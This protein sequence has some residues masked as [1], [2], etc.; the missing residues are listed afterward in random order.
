MSDLNKCFRCGMFDIDGVAVCRL[1][2]HKIEQPMSETCE[3][4]IQLD[5]AIDSLNVDIVNLHKENN[6][7]LETNKVISGAN[8]E[9]KEEGEALRKTIVD[10]CNLMRPDLHEHKYDCTL[11]PSYRKCSCVTGEREHFIQE[12]ENIG[13]KG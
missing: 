1:H 3:Y 12:N 7:H 10:A 5:D 8:H 2:G 11:T 13:C 9:L 6:D 4:L